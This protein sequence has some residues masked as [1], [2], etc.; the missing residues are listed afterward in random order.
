MYKN[1]KIATVFID[2]M[3]L[4][5]ELA[6]KYSK[7]SESQKLIFISKQSDYSNPP[8]SHIYRNNKLVKM[9]DLS[10]NDKPQKKLSR[11]RSKN[12]S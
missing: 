8:Y 2:G 7:L 10:R 12:K 5:E 11:Y 3:T 4:S 9:E 1:N 6:E